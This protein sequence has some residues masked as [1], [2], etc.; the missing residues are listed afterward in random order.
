MESNSY[1]KAIRDDRDLLTLRVAANVTV[2]RYI[3]TLPKTYV[4]FPALY[5][6]LL[7]SS[8]GWEYSNSA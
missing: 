2:T 6:I 4:C 3:D 5:R 7:Q 1:H 8:C